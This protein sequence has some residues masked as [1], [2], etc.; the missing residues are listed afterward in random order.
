MRLH[1]R[2]G[3]ISYVK[4]NKSPDINI[5]IDFSELPNKVR[6]LLFAIN[7]H[8]GKVSNEI[9]LKLVEQKSTVSDHVNQKGGVLQQM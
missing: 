3:C 4:E 1:S 2:G 7:F 5:L 6:I 9:R 8:K